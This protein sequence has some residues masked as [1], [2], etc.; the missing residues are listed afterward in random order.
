MVLEAKKIVYARDEARAAKAEAEVRLDI[1]AEGNTIEA[2]VD[3][4]FRESETG[5]R[6]RG[7]HMHDNPGYLVYYGFTLKVPARTNSS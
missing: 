7:I 6:S 2:Y 3:G 4:P 1:T 5:R